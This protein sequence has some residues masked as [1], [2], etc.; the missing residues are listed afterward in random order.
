MNKRIKIV[1]FIQKSLFAS[2]CL[3]AAY[4]ICATL[5]ELC[6]MHLAYVDLDVYIAGSI[7]VFSIAFGFISMLFDYH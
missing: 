7:C 4:S 1:R 6:Y 3:G 5:I 2:F